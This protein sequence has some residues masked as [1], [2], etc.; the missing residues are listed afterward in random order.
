MS[1]RDICERLGRRLH[2]G[3]LSVEA[4][5]ELRDA[6]AEIEKLRAVLHEQVTDWHSVRDRLVQAEGW[7][8]KLEAELNDAKAEIERLRAR[9]RTQDEIN[10]RALRANVKLRIRAEQAEAAYAELRGEAQ[11]L[12]PAFEHLLV[13]LA[14]HLTPTVGEAANRLAEKVASLAAARGEE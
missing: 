13:A 12:G 10:D 2:D 7:G 11:D 9:C 4:I 1:E 3:S 14:S 6:L 5:S 8:R